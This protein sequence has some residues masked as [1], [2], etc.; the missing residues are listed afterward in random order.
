M[1]ESFQPKVENLNWESNDEDIYTDVN[2][3]K[4][5]LE[6]VN[7]DD[8]PDNEPDDGIYT[9]VNGER[10]KLELVPKDSDYE[11]KELTIDPEDFKQASV[12]ELENTSIE[13]V[14]SKPSFNEVPLEDNDYEPQ[15]F[16]PNPDRVAKVEIDQPAASPATTIENNNESA[17]KQVYF[18]LKKEF[19][20]AEQEYY[21]ALDNDKSLLKIVGIG[22]NKLGE[23]AQV[24]YDKFIRTSNA[25]YRFG[26]SSGIHE[27]VEER[28]NRL[29]SL[30][31]P[32]QDSDSSI[33]PLMAERHVL[34]PAKKRLELQTF[35]I[36]NEKYI[37]AKSRLLEIVSKNPKL[38]KNLGYVALG[39]GIAFNAPGVLT[40]LLVNKIGGKFV[41]RAESLERES[42]DTVV[43]SFAFNAPNLE[44]L[45]SDYFASLNKTYNTK[46]VSRAATV[47]AAV[48]VGK[49]FSNTDIL[50]GVSNLKDSISESISN[51]NQPEDVSSL[52]RFLT[53]E[54]ITTDSVSGIEGIA[55]DSHTIKIGDNLSKIVSDAVRQQFES[56]HFNLPANIDS[57]HISHYLYQQLPEFTNASDVASRFTPQEWMDMGVSSGNPQIIQTGETID[58]NQLLNK[59][60]GTVE[61]GLG[62][63]PEIPAVENYVIPENELLSDFT[64]VEAAEIGPGGLP[65]IE[66]VDEMAVEPLPDY[67]AADTGFADT[68]STGEVLPDVVT[69]PQVE[70][71]QR[72]F[73]E[74]H[75]FNNGAENLRQHL[76]ERL[77]SESKMG[78]FD[79]PPEVVTKL[80]ANPDFMHV[81]VDR[82]FPEL[83]GKEGF[84]ESIFGGNNSDTL[85]A[86]QWEKLGVKGG[87]PAN[88]TLGSEVKVGEIKKILLQ[89]IA[90]DYSTKVVPS[91]IK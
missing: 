88:L 15:V 62:G 4:T 9:D 12:A 18:E 42:M 39:A 27:Q 87:D 80:N 11:V 75:V 64:S 65:E 74:T 45:E 68:F 84:L 55:V 26:K 32:E 5:K 23:E 19:K 14:D 54:T 21:S 29:K 43:D 52:A 47:A 69:Q 82:A 6:L 70:A 89:R 66:P 56:G 58:L 71:V 20:A 63:L 28:L 72:Y 17:E 13:D 44:A 83:S 40:G 77:L 36:Q 79:L 35:S 37:N 41:D 85:A 86:E 34:A 3:V 91:Y 57:D 7:D 24:A 61:I 78:I 46:A 25:F 10:V 33:N 67:Q 16:K 22:R 73:N 50:Q 48:G 38:A 60:N 31:N 51:L 49:S 2:G 1:N 53:P 90:E 81:L 8:S 59:L 30:K 76:A